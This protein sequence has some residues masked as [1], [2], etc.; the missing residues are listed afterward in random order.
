MPKKLIILVVNPKKI[1]Q[2]PLPLGSG[3]INIFYSAI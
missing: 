3:H 1:S 2:T